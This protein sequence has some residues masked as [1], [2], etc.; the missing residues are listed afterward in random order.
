MSL[1]AAPPATPSRLL[2]L[3]ATALAIA[4]LSSCGG[5]PGPA[6]WS[7]F[8]DRF[9]ESHFK[10][11]PHVAVDQGRHEYDGLLP[12]WSAAGLAR[13]V[14]RLRSYR[15]QALGFDPGGLAPEQRFERDDFIAV[16]EGQLFWLDTAAWPQRNPVYYRRGLDP[17]VY[18]SR[19]YA[20]LPNRMQSFT[21]WAQSVPEAVAQIRGNLR[22]PL[23]QDYIDIGHSMFGGL[24]AY[25]EHDVPGVF[26]QVADSKLRSQFN[27]ASAAAVEALRELDGWLESQRPRATDGFALGPELFSEMLRTTER[28][29]LPL[30]RLAAINRADT[31][32]NREAL[33]A[34][35]A[36]FA[37]GATIRDCIAKTQANKPPEGAVEGAR[38]Q[39]VALEEFLRRA[40]LVTIPGPERA[41]VEEAPPHRRTNAAYISIPGPYENDMP[42]VY[43]IAPPDPSWSAAERAAYVPGETRLLFISVHEVWPGHFLQH[44]HA[45]R[46][47]SSFGR[48]FVGYAFSEGWAHYSEEMMLEAGLGGGDPEV[49]IGQILNALRRNVRFMSALG[50]H[51]GGMTVAESERLFT[52]IAFLDPG[53][54]RQQA[55]R[56]TYDPA[57]LNYT[58]G[59]L[60]IRRMRDDWTRDR[61][62]QETW[63]DFHDRLLSYGGPPLPLV[64]R[65]L[66]GD[67]SGPPL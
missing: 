28:V 58:L 55:A 66:L 67:D 47:S 7:A 43:Y 14:V 42:S 35:C 18:L 17:N 57:Y 30:E 33:E 62:G 54:A 37:P 24:A 26:E 27:A 10:A 1:P 32:R 21:R 45:N 51:T 63:R 16:L 23:P 53:N 13:E 36:G 48:L 49:R 4:T 20:P 9:I 61:G 29:D 56:G 44:L 25:L 40:D 64:R 12:D 34:A 41:L 38:R 52:G 50:L 59:K 5:E 31:D 39:I 6:D 65:A 22:T 15:E 3:A 60:M 19:P 8:V 2:T 11:N 46:S